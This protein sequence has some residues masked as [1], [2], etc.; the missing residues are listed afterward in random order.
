MK[1]RE[2]NDVEKRGKSSKRKGENR[3]VREEEGDVEEGKREKNIENKVKREKK[4]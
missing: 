2:V 3:N 4:G 1:E